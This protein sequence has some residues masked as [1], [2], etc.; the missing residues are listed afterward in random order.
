MELSYKCINFTERHCGTAN[1]ELIVNFAAYILL[2]CSLWRAKEWGIE[3]PEPP[4]LLRIPILH[5]L[6]L[7]YICSCL[8]AVLSMLLEGFLCFVD[9]QF[10]RERAAFQRSAFGRST[11]GNDVVATISI[12]LFSFFFPFFPP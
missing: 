5:N 12:S 1:S 2:A 3:S 6:H 7:F 8:F 11:A 10:W 4:L 9:N